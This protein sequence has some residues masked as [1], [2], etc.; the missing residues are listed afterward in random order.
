MP[1]SV[2]DKYDVYL[3]NIQLDFFL[4]LPLFRIQ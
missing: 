3:T 1:D 4:F 2:T